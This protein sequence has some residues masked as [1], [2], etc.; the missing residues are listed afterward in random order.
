MVD[1]GADSTLLPKDIAPLLGID[2]AELNPTPRGSRGAGGTSFPTWT[3]P[4]V[5]DVGIVAFLP[6]GP[7]A[8]GPRVRLQPQFAENTTTL[9]GRADFFSYF[10]VIFEQSATRGS[11]FHLDH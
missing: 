10:T 3:T 8:W 9:L 1:S 4:K 2:D 6:D 5:L 11:V 7:Q